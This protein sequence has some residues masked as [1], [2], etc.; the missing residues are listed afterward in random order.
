[1]VNVTFPIQGA[2]NNCSET[3]CIDNISDWFDI[4]VNVHISNRAALVINCIKY[5]L[6]KFNINKLTLKQF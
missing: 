6:L 4:T 3:F 2:V 1:L 5:V